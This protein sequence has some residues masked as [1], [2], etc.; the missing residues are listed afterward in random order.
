[1]IGDTATTLSKESAT[2]LKLEELPHGGH[3]G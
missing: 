3:G 2:L 1:L